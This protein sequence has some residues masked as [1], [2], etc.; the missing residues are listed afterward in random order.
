MDGES[1]SHRL[2]LSHGALS[3]GPGSHGAAAQAV[4]RCDRAAL[5]AILAAG[6]SFAQALDEN[7]LRV[8][9]DRQAVADL[10]GT[11][12]AFSPMFNILEP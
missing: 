4:V 3:H 8:D 9:G 1:P 5:A 7:L 2:T 10:F 12:D 11:L 6:K